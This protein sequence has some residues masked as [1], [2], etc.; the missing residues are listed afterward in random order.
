MATLKYGNLSAEQRTFYIKTLLHRAEPELVYNNW[1]L[2]TSIPKNNGGNVQFRRF[3]LI[4]SDPTTISALTEGTAGANTT[5]SISSVVATVQQYGRWMEGTDILSDESADN[6]LTEFTE[7][8][9]KQA[10]IDLDVVTRE[11]LIAGSTVQYASTGASRGNVGSGMR[12]SSAEIREAVRTLSRNNAKR[13][14]SAGDRYVCV[15]HPDTW[16]DLLN[17]TDFKEAYQNAGDR[18]SS[19]ILFSGDTGDYNGVRFFVTTR[20]RIYAS[21]GLSGADVYQSLFLG[22]EAYATTELDTQALKVYYKPKESG[23][24]SNPLEMTWTL[25]Y[26]VAFAAVI[27]NDN[28]MVRLEHTTTYH[29][30]A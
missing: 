19:N 6:V 12:M 11:V 21:L 22:D 24:T 4:S 18:G 29:E 17:D 14:K 28:Y 7:V 2:K 5:P 25:G 26:K 20:A 1:A 27:L 8:F 3:E 9:G 10:G 23:G 16:A 15:I 13:V 30:Q